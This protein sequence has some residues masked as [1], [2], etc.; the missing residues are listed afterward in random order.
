MAVPSRLTLGSGQCMQEGGAVGVQLCPRCSS[1]ALQ[2]SADQALRTEARCFGGS[3]VG[4]R[5]S[6]LG[7]GLITQVMSSVSLSDS[8]HA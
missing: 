8:L 5:L 4:R 6:A 1:L 3:A 2:G 7:W